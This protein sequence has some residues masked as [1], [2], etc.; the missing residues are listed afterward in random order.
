[1]SSS[2]RSCQLYRSNNADATGDSVIEA[3]QR[4]RQH[5][6][7]QE[8]EDDE[9]EKSA[10]DGAVDDD[11]DD[12][13]KDIE[14]AATGTGNEKN[15]VLSSD[16]SSK[17][18]QGYTWW[19]TIFFILAL[20]VIVLSVSI[21][22]V[23]F[24]EKDIST[25]TSNTEDMHA[26]LPFES[27]DEYY[28]HVLS[29]VRRSPSNVTNIRRWT[30]PTEP[31]YNALQF[32]VYQD[33]L[34]N[35]PLYRIDATEVEQRLAVLIMYFA[36]GGPIF[37]TTKDWI[38]AGVH[39]CDWNFVECSQV[40]IASGPSDDNNTTEI[41]TQFV[42]IELNLEHLSLAYSLPTEPF[43]WLSQ[44]EV[45][46]VSHN[47]LQGTIP[48]TL[49]TLTHLESLYLERNDLEGQLPTSLSHLS[50][51]I[52]L[53]VD[54]NRL[55][56]PLPLYL[57]GQGDGT[58]NDADKTMATSTTTTTTTIQTTLRS[59]IGAMNQFTGSI[60]NTWWPQSHYNNNNGNTPTTATVTTATTS[61]TTDYAMDLLNLGYNLLTGTLPSELGLWTKLRSLT[62]TLN[63][64]MNGTVPTELGQLTNLQRLTLAHNTFTGTF[65]FDYIMPLPQ[66]MWLTISTN[67]LE[68]T[69]PASALI[70]NT[71]GATGPPHHH[72]N[73]WKMIALSMHSNKFSGTLPT[74]LGL[75]SSLKLVQ[76]SANQFSGTIPTAY[77][78]DG[79]EN[80]ETFWL[81]QNSKLTGTVPCQRSQQNPTTTTTTTSSTTTSTAAATILDFRSDCI[82]NP[83]LK[84]DC[85][86]Q[87]H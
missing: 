65:P 79:W 8:E 32:L 82:S 35:P 9:E 2:I 51:L 69:I 55:T 17:R 34:G 10:A 21:G 81:Y 59:F 29:I 43:A 58:Y 78:E 83:F 4:Q 15:T 56:G 30:D 86:K 54:D 12:D 68:G 70:R 49:W 60:P 19:W 36:T 84:C 31:Q 72:S 74:E 3:L 1:M 23:Y 73:P 75:V 71:P 27:L 50:H 20:I 25:V 48:W 37:W 45:L 61:P 64:G 18:Q 40:P 85:C 67:Q 28:N 14:T 13:D 87:C 7:R 53:N 5:Q 39:E 11:D 52:H 80:V 47:R 66:L 76:I 38:Q 57:P 33:T 16:P 62:L 24:K 44:L 6:R 22:V 41:T 77:L 42:V 26:P 63:G 46:D